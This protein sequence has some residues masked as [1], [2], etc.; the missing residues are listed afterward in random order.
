MTD[1]RRP[2]R[3]GAAAAMARAAEGRAFTV[4]DLVAGIGGWLGIVEGVVPPL[5]FVVVFQVTGDLLVSVAA[6]LALS[7][8]F[9]VYRLVRRQTPVAAVGGAVGAGLSAVLALVTGDPNNNFLPGIIQ[10][11]VYGAV[12]LITLLLRY[13]LL[14][15]AVSFLMNDQRTW[16]QD[17]RKLRLYTW[18]TLLW[19][20]LFVVRVLVMLPLYLAGDQLVAL[21]I[22][23]V[24]LGLPLYAPVLVLTVLAVQAFYRGA[25]KPAG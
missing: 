4:G 9:L 20:G 21:G 18:L 12:F 23:K 7:A 24:A 17:T 11:A 3:S 8:V 13:P 6:P 14:G 10:N 1:G 16:R 2:P 5:L 19:T 22:A 15:V 25:A